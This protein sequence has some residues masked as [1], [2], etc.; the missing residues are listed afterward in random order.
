MVPFK[1]EIRWLMQPGREG[2]IVGDFGCGEAL[3]AQAVADRH[4]V[5]SFDHC[6]LD[7]SNVIVCDVAS[8]PIEDATLDVAIFCLSLM[9]S[10]FTDYIR[11]AHRCLRID[12]QLHIWEPASYFDNLDSFCSGLARLGF[13]VL[14]PRKEGAFVCIRA[15]KNATV[16]VPELVLAFRGQGAMAGV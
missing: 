4:Q 14:S 5:Y 3:L 16:P 15:M 10:N 13:D 8:V 1:E 9:G 6:A 2:L 11:E 7:G 12:G